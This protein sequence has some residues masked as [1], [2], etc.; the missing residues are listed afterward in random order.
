MDTQHMNT[1]S[2]KALVT[3][4]PRIISCACIHLPK[5]VL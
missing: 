3:S 4:R 5:F 1:F 2:S